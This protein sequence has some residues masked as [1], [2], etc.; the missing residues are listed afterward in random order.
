MGT[1]GTMAVLAL[2]LACSVAGESSRMVEETTYDGEYERWTS[3]PPTPMPEPSEAQEL[4]QLCEV[5][6]MQ[7]CK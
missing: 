3:R 5:S 7:R 2:L 4:E 6:S 1:M